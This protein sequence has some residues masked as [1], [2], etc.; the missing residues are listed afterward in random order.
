MEEKYLWI[1]ELKQ[2]LK[3]SEHNYKMEVNMTPISNCISFFRGKKLYASE[4]ST[5]DYFNKL[6]RNRNIIIF[7]KENSY[8]TFYKSFGEELKNKYDAFVHWIRNDNPSDEE[9]KDAI[10]EIHNY[11]RDMYLLRSALN[12][13]Y[14]H[15]QDEKGK[16][17]HE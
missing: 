2:A 6:L 8:D 3:N 7:F 13:E 12:F 15:I 5:P 17:K 1:E 4:L 16:N 9:I 11:M 10:K 14:L